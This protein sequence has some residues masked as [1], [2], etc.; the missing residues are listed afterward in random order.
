MDDVRES[1]PPEAK[2]LR[3]ELDEEHTTCQICFTKFSTSTDTNNQDENIKDLLPVSS[4]SCDHYFCHGCIT[5]QQV[6]I[7][8]ERSGRVP[9]W[10]ECMTC[11]T[12]TA[13]CPS[14][15]RYHRLLIDFLT[16]AQWYDQPV[17]V[18]KKG[19]D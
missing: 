4:E 14:K 16:R 3:V 11:K 1:E 6:S 2:R 15:P 17:G 19:E 9:K 12:K 8:E 13:F 5:M 10:I 18:K 7:A